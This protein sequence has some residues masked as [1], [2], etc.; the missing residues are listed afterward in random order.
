MPTEVQERAE[1]ADRF[2]LLVARSILVISV[3][4][5]MRLSRISAYDIGLSL[6]NWKSPFATGLAVSLI[7]VGLNA[8]LLARAPTK[9]AQKDLESHGPVGIWCGLIV[10]GS[11][12]SEFWRAFCI[13]AL[14]RS[15][16]AAWLAIVI[17]TIFCAALWLQTSIARAL[18][19]AFY[20]GVAGTLFVYTGSLLAPLAMGLIASAAHFYR[21]RYKLRLLDQ[22]KAKGGTGHRLSL[23]STTCPVCGAMFNSAEVP[24]SADMLACPSCGESLT[25]EKRNLWLVFAI[26]AAVA[27][28]I[29]RHLVYRDFG[30]LLVTEGL[31]FVLTLIG[32]VF[33]GI[34]LPPK[35]KRVDGGSFDDGLSLL[36]T[37][38]PDRGKKSAQK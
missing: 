29:T 36:G 10:L 2:A 34:L 38:N 32:A 6:E 16:V 11:F 27:F 33:S 26:S 28:Y 12:S 22:I 4:L 13:V 24:H 19:A 7:S 35:Y 31:A 21:V 14:L 3:V 23:Y 20:G 37:E 5:L 8:I 25:T 30:Y 9:S 18:G 15:G 17:V 1:D